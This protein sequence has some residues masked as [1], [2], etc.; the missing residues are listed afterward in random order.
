MSADDYLFE[1]IVSFG[2]TDNWYITL[3]M[4]FDFI[5]LKTKYLPIVYS[6]YST[7]YYY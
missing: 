5:R 7:H 6:L 3:N 1:I 2:T 4:N